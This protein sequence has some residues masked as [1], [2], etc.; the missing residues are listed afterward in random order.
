M[1]ADKESCPFWEIQNG[2]FLRPQSLDAIRSEKGRI[3]ADV[4]AQ[5]DNGLKVFLR[6]SLLECPNPFTDADADFFIILGLP[7]LEWV[8]F[9]SKEALE[10]LFAG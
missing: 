8:T 1:S 5:I 6:G 4:V 3:L 9:R 2:R 10:A 7:A